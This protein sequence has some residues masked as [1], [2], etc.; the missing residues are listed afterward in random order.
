MFPNQINDP[1]K[2]KTDSQRQERNRRQI[3]PG[4]SRQREKS[5]SKREEQQEQQ[6]TER[7]SSAAIAYCKDQQ[8]KAGND[9]NCS[10]HAEKSIQS[11]THE[12]R[13]K[14]KDEYGSS[15]GLSG[16]EIVIMQQDPA[17]EQ[18]ACHTI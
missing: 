10:P 9:G 7:F 13:K 4:R 3:N 18:N 17:Q 12:S 14:R 2:Q 6:R 1:V 5:H 15:E 8:K 16:F 11:F